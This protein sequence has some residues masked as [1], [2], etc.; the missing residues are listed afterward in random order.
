M[1]G[2]LNLS[3]MFD[4]RRGGGKANIISLKVFLDCLVAFLGLLLL[5]NFFIKKALGLRWLHNL[6][7]TLEANIRISM[8]GSWLAKCLPR[9]FV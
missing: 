5:L 8:I 7:T 1:F 3:R 4:R 9:V 2:T 6:Q